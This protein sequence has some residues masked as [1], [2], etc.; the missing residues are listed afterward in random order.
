MQIMGQIAAPF[1]F[2][3]HLLDLSV[4]DFGTSSFFAPKIE[5]SPFSSC[6]KFLFK[7]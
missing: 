7:R 2:F 5:L 3:S 1:R 6:A 4:I